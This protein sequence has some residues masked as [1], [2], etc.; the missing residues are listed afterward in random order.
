MKAHLKISQYLAGTFWKGLFLSCTK[1]ILDFHA[2][3]LEL[4]MGSK[5]SIITSI[6]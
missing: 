2:L 6:D 5:K 1:A 4:V 3:Y